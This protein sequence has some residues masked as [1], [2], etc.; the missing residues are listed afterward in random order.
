MVSAC[1][2]SADKNAKTAV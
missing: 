1:A 2:L